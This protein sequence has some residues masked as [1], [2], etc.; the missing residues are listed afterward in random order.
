MPW[1]HLGMLLLLHAQLPAGGLGVA[2]GQPAQQV[3]DHLIEYQPR[4]P[5]PPHSICCAC[6]VT[7]QEEGSEEEGEE[8]EEEEEEEQQEGSIG[9][10]AVVRLAVVI[11]F[12]NACRLGCLVA[13]AR[14]VRMKL[15]PCCALLPETHWGKCLRALPAA[16][17]PAGQRTIY[18]TCASAR[19]KTSAV[20]STTA[21]IARRPCPAASSH[22]RRLNE[23]LPARPPA[24]LPLP[25]AAA[26]IPSGP[27]ES[28]ALPGGRLRPGCAPVPG[29][30]PAGAA[31]AG[32]HAQRHPGRRRRR[33][34]PGALTCAGAAAAGTAAKPKAKV[35]R[36]KSVTATGGKVPMLGTQVGQGRGA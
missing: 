2:P 10:P 8:D 35:A 11:A 6:C 12:I 14:G 23:Q 33:R 13:A 27:R 28:Q 17:Q 22:G 36:G 3:P 19:P 18:L 26:G 15:S 1:T 9:Q 5:A 25:P 31:R 20:C 16:E 24:C 4:L 34:H 29:R 32:E 7:P 30:L 21:A